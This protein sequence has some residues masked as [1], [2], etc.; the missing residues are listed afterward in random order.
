[1]NREYA[2]ADAGRLGGDPNDVGRIE[3][4]GEGTFR[5]TSGADSATCAEGTV[6]EWKSVLAREDALAADVPADACGG[7]SEGRASWVRISWPQRP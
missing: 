7:L 1:M 6:T 2:I 3:T 5:F 4:D